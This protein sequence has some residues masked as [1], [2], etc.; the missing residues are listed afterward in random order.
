LL[1]RPSAADVAF[2][3]G[4]RG[5]VVVLGAG[6][7]M[8]PSLSRL[9]RRASDAAGRTRRVA[10]V[11]RFSAPEVA[12]ELEAH[13][14]DA[15]ACDLLD[16][17]AVEGLPSFD[18]VLFLAGM[19]FGA[20]ARP[21]LTWALN[22]VVPAHVAR[23]FASSR[24]V[25]FST[26]NVYP[27]SP[28]PQGGSSEGD[29]PGPVGE[30]AQSCLGRERVFEHYSRE[31]GTE[32]V[33]FRLFYAVDLRYGVLVD[34]ARKVFAGEPVD[35]TV[36]HANVIWQGDASSYALRSLGLGASPPLAL[37]VTGG[38]VLSVRD[39]ALGYGARFGREPVIVGTEGPVALLGNSS[40]C[41]ARLGEPAVSYARLFEWVAHW[42]ETGGRS[43]G[44]PTKFERADGRF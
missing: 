34:V 7:K 22:T 41:R 5:D 32:A 38:E 8:G 15:I 36:G 21:D 20:S 13:G 9:V 6:G 2:M 29:L 1:S 11:S 14:I 43:L 23:R 4:L 19:K 16:P 12:R 10:A 18:N 35:V 40:L 44:K 30:Y 25:V 27:L 31:R 33:L 28:V 37:N 3:A 26:G 17:V 42:V 39:V 24:M